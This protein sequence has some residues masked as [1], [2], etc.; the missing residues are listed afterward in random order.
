M[1]LSWK[2]P[3]DDG[4]CSITGYALF[5]DD[6]VTHKPTIEI[7]SINDIEIRNKP[8]LRSATARL[9]PSDL[10]TKYTF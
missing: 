10:G 6:G 4:G 1:N 3:T 9:N 8:T 2:E 7:N 5:R